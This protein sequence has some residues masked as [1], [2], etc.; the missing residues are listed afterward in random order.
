MCVFCKN[1][2]AVVEDIIEEKKARQA[3][4]VHL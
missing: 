1:R 3:S 4:S 2:V